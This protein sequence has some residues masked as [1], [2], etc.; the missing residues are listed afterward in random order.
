MFVALSFR[1]QMVKESQAKKEYS[2]K[3]AKI[4]EGNDVRR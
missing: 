1:L 3:I 4:E 2:T